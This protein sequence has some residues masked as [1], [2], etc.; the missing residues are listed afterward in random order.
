M[1]PRSIEPLGA[2]AHWVIVIIDDTPDNVTV[3]KTALKYHGAQVHT[4][5]NAEDGLAILECIEPTAV[6]LDIRMPKMDG[7]TM[8]R[9][10]RENP[11]T[12]HLP[13]IAITAY[14]MES[15]REDILRG[16]FDGYMP[17]P[18]DM[19]TFV[20]QID[21]CLKQ[22]AQKRRAAEDANL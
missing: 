11:K 8:L 1:R 12:S 18:F 21:Q 16:G 3:A 9:H 20:T 19:F 2:A 10:I 5:S 14:A 4:A 15:D 22:A 6:L 13:V 17:K 7:W